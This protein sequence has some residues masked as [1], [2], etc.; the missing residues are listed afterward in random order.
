MLN[1]ENYQTKFVLK[2]YTEVSKKRSEENEII[3]SGYLET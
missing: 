2:F 3:M 1:S